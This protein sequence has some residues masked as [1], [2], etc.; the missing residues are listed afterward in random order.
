MLKR[1]LIVSFLSLSL[2]SPALAYS[3]D[4]EKLFTQED[5]EARFAPVVTRLVVSYAAEKF[6]DAFTDNALEKVAKKVVEKVKKNFKNH[7]SDYIPHNIKQ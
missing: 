4:D 5:V 6:V 1:I 3:S 2:S 7:V